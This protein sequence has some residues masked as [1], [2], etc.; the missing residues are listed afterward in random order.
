MTAAITKQQKDKYP[1]MLP[2]F[3]E[4]IFPMPRTWQKANK[5]GSVSTISW[6]L[7]KQDFVESPPHSLLDI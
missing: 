4:W 2:R 7:L 5:E 1:K 6:F 3:L